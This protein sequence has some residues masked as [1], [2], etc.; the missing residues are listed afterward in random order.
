MSATETA[1]RT[2]L[3]TAGITGP[4]LLGGVR[5]YSDSLPAAC[6]FIQ[7]VASPAPVP[8]M[9]GTPTDWR[10]IRILIR[11]RA[12]PND[13]LTGSTKAEA[14]Y[15]AMQKAVISG[16][17]MVTVESSAP[18]FLG[19]DDKECPEWVIPVKLQGRF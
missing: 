8:Y 3:I 5:P 9:D 7:T 4:V 16:F 13:Y 2:H 6:T 18:A 11:V 15:G 12:A 10:P 1:V 17:T 14:I 19:R